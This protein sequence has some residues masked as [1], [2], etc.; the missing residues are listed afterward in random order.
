MFSNIISN[1]RQL[2]GCFVWCTVLCFP[3]FVVGCGQNPYQRDRVAV[4]GKVYLEDQLI[5]KA[6]IVFVPID[7]DDGPRATGLIEMGM[8]FIDKENGP[9][10]GKL[11]VEI[12]PVGI[13][14]AEFEE[15]ARSGEKFSALAQEIPEKLQSHHSPQR[16]SVTAGEENWLELK[17]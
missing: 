9:L 2:A 8:F 13:E 15:K 14:L 1:V 17:F 5:E 3:L 16:V 4:S 6:R 7:P 12:H 10:E 11:R